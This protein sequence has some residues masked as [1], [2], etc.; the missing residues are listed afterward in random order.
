M[1]PL[2]QVQWLINFNRKKKMTG[3][4]TTLYY[5]VRENIH[6]LVSWTFQT[7]KLTKS[8]MS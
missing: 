3:E 5:N 4:K 6:K 8:M 2:D 1:H 7:I